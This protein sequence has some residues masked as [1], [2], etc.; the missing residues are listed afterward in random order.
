MKR[1][2]E[3]LRLLRQRRGLTL[4]QLASILD[5]RAHSQLANI[6]AGKNMPTAELI[7][8]ISDFF[9]VSLDN[10]MRDELELDE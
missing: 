1:F 10:L 5:M 4:R 7:L 2:G 6:E 3:K 8:K 9:G